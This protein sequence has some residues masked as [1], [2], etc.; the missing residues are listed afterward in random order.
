MAAMP[1]VFEDLAHAVAHGRGRGQRQIDDAE[2]HA[3]FGRHLAAD[4]FADARHAETGDLDLFGQIAQRQMLFQGQPPPQGA[5]YHARAGDADIDHGL[6]LAG[7]EIGPGHEGIVL[8]DIGKDHQLGAAEA[9]VLGRGR[10][11]LQEDMAHPLDGVHVDSRPPRSDVQRCAYPLRL[12]QD[13]RQRLHHDRIAGR[14]ALVNQ[15]REAAHE[16]DAAFGRHG[17]E[18]LGQLHGRAVAMPG[19]QGGGGRNRHPLVD[20]R[21]AVLGPHAIAD[22]D[23]PAGARSDLLPHLAAEMIQIRR[24]TVVKVQSQGDAA[25]V[26]VLGV[27]HVDGGEDFV[28][29]EHGVKLTGLGLGS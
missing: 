10:G 8:G 4:Q 3:E 21:Y 14:N 24:R 1:R 17:V 22:L 13:L 25:N 27:Q 12:R 11:D 5:A 19:Q 15:G 29:A 18:R 2:R 16:V 26:E 9:P 20:H 7:A 6:R 23:Q 28:G